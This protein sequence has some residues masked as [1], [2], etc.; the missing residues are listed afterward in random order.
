MKQGIVCLQS[1][2]KKLLKH[3]GDLPFDKIIET[4]DRLPE[5]QSQKIVEITVRF[6][7]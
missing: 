4:M 2:A 1:K 3:W 5:R 7:I 6:F